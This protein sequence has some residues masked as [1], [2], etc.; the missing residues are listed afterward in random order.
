MPF[1]RAAA[2][3]RVICGLQRVPS[4]ARLIHYGE[5]VAAI[6]YRKALFAAALPA[7]E[8]RR[9]AEMLS[10]L[11]DM[12]CTV[13][14]HY[15][16]VTL[17]PS[18][19]L[20]HTVRCKTLFGDFHPGKIYSEVPLFYEEW[21]DETSELLLTC[22]EEVQGLC[23]ALSPLELSFVRSL[24]E[25]YESTTPQALTRKIRSIQGFKG[26]TS[27]VLRQGQGFVPDFESR[28]FRADFPYGLHI[29]CEIAALAGHPVPTL[30]LLYDW[31][32]SLAHPQT[33]FSFADYGIYSAE[34]LFR[35]YA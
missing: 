32:V 34:D 14:P 27:P 23:R 13:L 31:Y 8:G 3:G 15:L 28:Y 12:S 26:L 4:V 35:C 21:T 22:D 1:L 7:G 2:R 10:A 33:Q 19:P 16:N 11:F 25:H 18:N 29:L 24:R 6:G 9:C 17:T 30:T 20:L 5:S